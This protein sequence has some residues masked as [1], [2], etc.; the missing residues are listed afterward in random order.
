MGCGEQ[1]AILDRT[2][3]IL[4]GCVRIVEDAFFRAQDGKVI[5]P[6]L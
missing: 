1:I 2:T 4:A 6:P 5:R 3:A